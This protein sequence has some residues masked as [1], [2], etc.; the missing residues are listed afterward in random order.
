MTTMTEK[1][2]QAVTALEA[3]RQEGVTLTAYAKA[4]GL[5]VG[6]LY[7]ILAGL[8][9]KGLLARPTRKARS[10]FVAVRVQA[11]TVGRVSG[12]DV[13]CRIAHS[14]GLLIECTQWPPPSWLN[15]LTVE[16]KDAAT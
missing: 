9:R 3:A 15:A 8:R 1:Q 4:N 7:S 16:M 5:V 12:S 10:R 2:Q 11:P 14:G 6:D 13:L